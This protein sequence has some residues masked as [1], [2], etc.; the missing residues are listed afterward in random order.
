MATKGFVVILSGPVGAGKTTV[1]ARLALLLPPP[2]ANIEGDAFWKFLATGTSAQ[3]PHQNF[4]TIM[5]AMMTAAIPLALDGYNV[6]IDFSVPPKFLKVADYLFKRRDI[7]LKYV[8]I[9]PSESICAE[10]AASRPTGTISDYS[11]YHEFY[12][13]FNEAGAY[14]ITDDL[15]DAQSLAVEIYQGLNDGMFDIT[16]DGT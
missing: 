8:V 6:I 10:R 5:K 9:K 1:A 3:S 16:G 11:H 4:K 14:I 12:S 7:S 15:S 13:Y 2:A